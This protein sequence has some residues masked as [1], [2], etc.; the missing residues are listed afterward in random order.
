MATP[1]LT[2]VLVHGAWHG[3]WCWARVA[4]RLRGAGHRVLTPTLTGHGER[5]HLLTPEVGLDTFIQDIIAALETDEVTDAVLVGHSL[6]GGPITGAADRVPE[7]IA[8]LIYLD[9]ALPQDGESVFSRYAPEIVAERRK[10]AQETSG[11]LTLPAPP[12]ASFGVTAKEDAAWLAHNLRPEPFR[13]FEDR[14]HLQHPFGN[15][16]K[17]TY[18]A[19]VKPTYPPAAPAHDHARRQPG[20]QYLEL[21][22]GHD[23]MILAPVE[24]SDMLRHMAS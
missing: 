22:T 11:G 17:I 23:A 4:E 6:A 18:I 19:C 10:L 14:L 1:S 8:H 12:P 7:R 9:A 21:A 20:W 3:G 13:G 15:G 5:A 16:R 24:L 2:F